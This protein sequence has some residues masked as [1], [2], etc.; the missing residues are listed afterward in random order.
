M[1][2]LRDCALVAVLAVTASAAQATLYFSQDSNANGLYAIDT[3]TAAATHLGA[4]G[5][6]GST[7]GL[8]PS[9]N[10]NVLF[11]TSFTQLLHINVDGSGATAVGSVNAEGLAYDGA[12]GTLYGQLNNNFFTVDPNTGAHLTNLAS[13]IGDPDGLTFGRGGVFGVA[14]STDSLVFYNVGLDNWTT[15][16]ALGVAIND[17]GLAYDALNDILYAMGSAGDLFAVDP[18]S[19][20]AT[21]I[22]NTGLVGAGGL[23]FVSAGGA[24]PEP[25]A[26]ALCAFGLAGFARSRRRRG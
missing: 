12:T 14:D 24:V 11:G 19:G 4:S 3:L 9:G 15:V 1:R 18:D 7:V 17:P 20:Q 8:S 5:V 26:L 10:P 6:G 21:L 23:A 25:G 16:G 13:A 2:I 22:G